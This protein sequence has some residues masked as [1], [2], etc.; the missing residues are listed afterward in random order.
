M[1]IIISTFR[2]NDVDRIVAFASNIVGSFGFFW[3]YT[4]I[5]FVVVISY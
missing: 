4:F 1:I 2:T 5:K 3:F